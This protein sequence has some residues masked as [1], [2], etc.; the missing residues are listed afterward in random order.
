M[1]KLIFGCA[2]MISGMIGSSAWLIAHILLVEPGAWSSVTNIFPLIGFGGIDGIIVI[3]F[4]GLAVLG[5]IMAIR[6]LKDKD[7]N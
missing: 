4:F 7:G 5:A 2:L 1:K 3:L 6:S